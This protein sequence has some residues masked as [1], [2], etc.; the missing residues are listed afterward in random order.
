[1]RVTS[2]KWQVGNSKFHSSAGKKAKKNKQKLLEL[3]SSELWKT[4]KDLQQLSRCWTK[5]KTKTKGNFKT[6]GK[7]CGIFYLLMPQALPQ[8]SGNIKAAAVQ[9][10]TWSLAQ[11]GAEWSLFINDCVCLFWPSGICRTSARCSPLSHLTRNSGCKE[12]VLIKNTASKAKTPQLPGAKDYSH[13]IQQTSE[14]LRVRAGESFFSKLEHVKAGM[15][16]EKYAESCVSPEHDE[17]SEK[18]WEYTKL[19]TS[20]WSL[21]A[22][23]A[24]LHSRECPGLESI[25]K[26]WERTL[27]NTGI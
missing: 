16:A 20:D 14:G 24:W 13:N 1:M 10:S 22:V 27:F 6:V 25:W 17:C 5:K 15:Y 7:L 19:F 9:I 4:A 12:L 3:T 2:V 26:Y 21:H 18:T 8:N 11:E 23:K